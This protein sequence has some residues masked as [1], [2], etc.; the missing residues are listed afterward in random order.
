VDVCQR[1]RRAGLLHA[2]PVVSAQLGCG[3]SA[4]QRAFDYGDR[5]I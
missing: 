2:V 4:Q 3:F 1:D 5:E